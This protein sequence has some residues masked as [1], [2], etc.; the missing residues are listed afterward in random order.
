[1]SAVTVTLASHDLL[2]KPALRYHATT[3]KH[4]LLLYMVCNR[5]GN[6][7]YGHFMSNETPQSD[8]IKT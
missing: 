3:A 4:Y 2:E 1:M 8:K 6:T 5:V 7:L